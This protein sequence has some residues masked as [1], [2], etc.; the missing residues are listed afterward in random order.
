M[1]DSGGVQGE[2]GHV[3]GHLK[4]TVGFW[5][6]MFVSLGSII[7]SGWL[8]SALSASEA[9][10]PAAILSW[11]LAAV[12]LTVLA[13]V[14]AELGATYPVAGGTG[15]YPYFSHGPLAGFVAGWS[16]WLQA[17]LIAPIE[18]LAAITY[19]NSLE[20]VQDNFNMVYQSGSKEGLLNG[21]G[22]VVAVL[23]MVLFTAINLAGAHFMSE[24]NSIVVIWKTAVPLLAIV[25][26]AS[27]SFHWGNF[28]SAGGGFMPYGIHGVF[29]ALPL[30]VVF[31]L[32][33]FEQA[34]QLAG[35]AR[36]PKRDI[37]RA[38]IV[39]MA[40]G[41]TIY[42][43]LQFV[44]IGAVNPADIAQGWGSPLGPGASA[45]QGAWH[46]LAVAVG[47]GWLAGIIVVDG[48]ISPAGTGIVYVGTSAR[49]SYALGEERE[50]PAVLASVNKTGTPVF[51]ILLA[52]VV[53]VL[54]FGP[55]PSW[56]K[57]VNVVTGT[58]AIMYA[59]APVS[60]AAL[61]RRDPDRPRT[62]VAPLSAILMP[63]A[64][65]FA[66]LLLYWGGFQTMWK[67]DIALIVGVVLF[68]IGVVVVKT[69]WQH[70]IRPALWILPWLAGMTLIDA[71]GRY[72][73]KS[74]GVSSHTHIGNWW[75][76]LLVIGF[77]LVIFYY[78]V[79][80]AIS[81]ERVKDLVEVD[82]DQLVPEP[83]LV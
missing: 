65:C 4:R 31:A 57:L 72:T 24:S 34:V 19:A 55:F 39:A 66:S 28:H 70:M 78:A 61:R 52:F 22:L 21:L 62:Y 10:G 56:N 38:I 20:T 76:L 3:H 32:Q 8:L 69:D 17:V 13:L 30:G 35:E 25:V 45:D 44:F 2:H 42:V 53:G 60:L 9:A 37:S 43:L 49:L 46:T 5:G 7:G 64:F 68:A 36:D 18:V 48:V 26:I 23:G 83:E 47:A 27:Q 11:A 16:S 80:V 74:N 79:S 41:G 73:S 54:A 51:S 50:M 29:V 63:A 33:G 6:L 59:F 77:S 71:F 12:M 14:Y 67:I 82:H 1:H 58:T 15:R 75:D 40:V 81:T